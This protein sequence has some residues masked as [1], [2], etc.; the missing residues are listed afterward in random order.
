M[1]QITGFDRSANLTAV[2]SSI[3]MPDKFAIEIPVIDP[4]M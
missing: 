4:Y 2:P 3:G 1:F